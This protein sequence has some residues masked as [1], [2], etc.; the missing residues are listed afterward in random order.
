MKKVS[1]ILLAS[2]YA[3]SIF[4][5]G[6]K[7]FYCC[8]KLKSIAVSFHQHNEK[9]STNGNDASNCCKTKYQFFKVKDNHVASDNFNSPV[10]FFYAPKLFYASNQTVFFVVRKNIITNHCNA[11]PLH[12]GIPIY[13]SDRTFLI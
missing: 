2:I 7:G 1:L 13:I 8:G 10:D 5:Y 6:V 4:G 11:P 12:N 3:L 9:E